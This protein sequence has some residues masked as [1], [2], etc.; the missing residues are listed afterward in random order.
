MASPEVETLVA[1]CSVAS[2]EAE[3][4]A[5]SAA[6]VA[7]VRSAGRMYFMPAAWGGRGEPNIHLG[8]GNHHPRGRGQ[9]GTGIPA[10]NKFCTACGTP[11]GV[12]MAVTPAMVAAALAGGETAPGAEASASEP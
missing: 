5:G 1:C 8:V 6:T 2:G 11:S 9:C 10:G 4:A 3:A 7:A 12:H